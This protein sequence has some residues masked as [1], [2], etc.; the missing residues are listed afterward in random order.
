MTHPSEPDGLSFRFQRLGRE[1]PTG[2]VDYDVLCGLV[3]DFSIVVSGRLLYQE[4]PLPVVEL[5]AA[6]LRWLDQAPEPGEDFEWD[7]MDTE[8]PGWVWFRSCSQGWRVG[9]LH[10]EY[11]EL[12]EFSLAELRQAITEFV[13]RL[14]T[15]ARHEQG[16]DLAPYLGHRPSGE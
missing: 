1:P 12:R 10:Q 13:T 5:A 8:E 11:P 2:H 15:A 9:S 4:N 6:L 14:T 7:S 16:I 3:A